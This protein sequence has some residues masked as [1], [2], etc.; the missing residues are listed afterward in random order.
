MSEAPLLDVRGVHKSFFGVPVLRGV[1]F[2]VAP[3]TTL[4]LVGE[5]GA[6]KSTL[7]NVLGGVHRPDAGEMRLA[8]ASYAPAGPRDATRAGVAFIHQELNL[9]TNLSVAENLFIGAL[10]RRRVGGRLR[11]PLTDRAALDRAARAALARVDLDIDPA[12]VVGRLSPGQRQLAEI[13]RAL[14]A[15][16]RLIILDEPTTSLTAPEARRLFDLMGRL[17]QRGISMIY[18]SHNLE[19]VLALCD[20]I[21]VL[22]DGQLVSS[23]P[24]GQ[25][26]RDRLIAAM[27]GRA[28]EPSANVGA[29]AGPRRPRG[30]EVLRVEQLA[31]PPAVRGVSLSLHAG[32]I[33]GVAGLMGAGR[34]ELARLIFGVDRARGGRVL[35]RGR[36]FAPSPRASV[37]AGLAFL[38]EN[39]REEGLMMDA[40]LLDNAGLVAAGAFTRAGGASLD[41]RRMRSAVRDASAAVHLRA[42]GLSSRTP[43]TLSG[44]N[45]QKVVLE[46]WLLAKPSVI[47][48]DEPT[49]GID[50][51]AKREI[52]RLIGSLAAGGAAVLVVSSELEELLGLC[53][54]LVVMAAG[55][56]TAEFGPAEF[57][58]ERILA[59]ALR[60][61]GDRP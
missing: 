7:M 23:G 12:T 53:D 5:N 6:G 54:R 48:L 26:T 3:G 21:A 46:K 42:A 13:A 30:Q 55:R 24:R 37:A 41:R 61:A 43:R 34:T 59:A 29:A 15:E 16:A 32:E 10:P 2:V 31:R 51:G 18:I 45:Q 44:G 1:S 60:T 47:L 38:T 28:V 8:G 25:Y 57:D 33:L 40:S 14:H 56:I 52:H 35:L 39:R 4:G 22:R 58:R 9:F 17:R 36:P 19:D 49:R 20:G 27:V 50:V 11:L